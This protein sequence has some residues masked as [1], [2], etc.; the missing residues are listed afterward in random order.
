MK[1]ILPPEEIAYKVC[2]KQKISK[3][4]KENQTMFMGE[5]N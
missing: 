4:T 3:Q 1:Q 5:D 2:G